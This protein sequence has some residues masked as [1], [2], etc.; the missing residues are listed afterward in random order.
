MRIIDT[1]PAGAAGAAPAARPAAKPEAAAGRAAGDLVTVMGLAEA[2]L[3]PGVRAA[4]TALM[5]EVDRLRRELQQSHRRVEHLERLAD[6]DTLLPL[7]N[8]RAFLR[9]LSRMMSFVERYGAASSVLYFDVNDLKKINDA[10][11]HAAG[12]AALRRIATILAENLRGSD[13][14]ARLGGDEFGVILAQ[15]D[16][17][18]AQEKA[19]VL[20]ALVAAEPLSWEGHAIP[21][22]VA[23]GIH[24]LTAA[25]GPDAALHA[26]DRAMYSDKRRAARLGEAS[27]EARAGAA[28]T[29][30]PAPVKR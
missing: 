18:A 11:G 20:V 2:E 9:E 1:R 19:A 30:D 5:A 7:A 28:A 23:V 10:H 8:R 26:A 27:G 6:Q 22:S 21:L 14:V 12:D 15:A 24:P 13:F 3:S 16:R 4:L 29:A 25:G 17:A